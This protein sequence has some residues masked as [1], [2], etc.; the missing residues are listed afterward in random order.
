MRLL[1]SSH[2]HILISLCLCVLACILTSL[3]SRIFRFISP[4]LHPYILISSAS[5]ELACILA[6]SHPHIIKFICGCLYTRMLIS[7]DL[8][9]FACIL[10]SSYPQVYVRLLVC[11]HPQVN[12]FST[13]IINCILASSSSLVPGICVSQFVNNF[14][15]LRIGQAFVS[16][17]CRT[18]RKNLSET[19]VQKLLL[20]SRQ[21]LW[22]VPV[23]ESIF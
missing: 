15:I 17:F 3:H 5:C 2:P 6:S 10:A 4:F 16:D 20:K 13:Q 19:A 12:V 1:V 18:S 7:S 8:Y 14:Q 22:K 11:S 21:N 9:V 23:K